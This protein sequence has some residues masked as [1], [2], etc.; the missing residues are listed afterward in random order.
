MIL[1]TLGSIRH[2]SYFVIFLKFSQVPAP[3]AVYWYT[4][5]EP[6]QQWR[7]GLEQSVLPRPPTNITAVVG[8]AVDLVCRGDLHQ[9]GNFFSVVWY[10][11]RGPAQQRVYVYRH[12]SG[13]SKAEGGWAGRAR[14]RYY[15][16]KHVMAV[17]LNPVG[18]ADQVRNLTAAQPVTL[19]YFLPLAARL[20]LCEMAV[21]AHYRCE[22]TYED[23]AGRW[24]SDSC[25]AAQLT[26]LAVL[27]Q[28]DLF[29][30]TLSNGT[31]LADRATVKHLQ[32]GQN[33]SLR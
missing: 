16:A 6:G 32:Q 22:I 31:E 19:R 11:E 21:K 26:S 27:G 18:L 24:F 12:H 8:V 33:I 28:P 7:H 25:L 2:Y 4:Y 29:S 17:T 3:I 14:H 10:R 20:G 1:L 15:A 5:A 13:G 9:C 23:Q 30:V